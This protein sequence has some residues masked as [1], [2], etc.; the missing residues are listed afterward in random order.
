MNN[1]GNGRDLI[2]ITVVIFAFAIGVFVLYF[3]FNS[4][5]DKML[6]IPQIN[7]SAKTVESLQASK[8]T[9]ER[10]DYIVFSVF[11]GMVLALMVTSWFV[12]G[13]PVF[14]FIYFVMIIIGVA[15]SAI[16]ANAWSDVSQS[17]IF[18]STVTHFPLTNHLL[19]YYPIYIAAVGVVGLIV[20][21]AKPY[22]G[23]GQ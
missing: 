6:D 11:M 22:L 4:S 16:K 13:N 3:M 5:V 23:D 12:S 7:D 19:S 15:I 1:L 20:M 10:F 2:L 18:G 17:S 9:S 21:F 8:H 14:M